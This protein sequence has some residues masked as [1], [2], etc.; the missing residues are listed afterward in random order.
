MEVQLK[1]VPQAL[2]QACIVRSGKLI[3]QGR[4]EGPQIIARPSRS[5]VE[6]KQPRTL[7]VTEGRNSIEQHLVFPSHCLQLS[8]DEIG[9]T[10]R[11][12]QH[13]DALLSKWDHGTCP[14]HGFWV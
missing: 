8:G 3:R 9:M 7:E 10:D 1:D 14:H 5:T 12:S 13:F 11:R 2:P 6:Q 4:S